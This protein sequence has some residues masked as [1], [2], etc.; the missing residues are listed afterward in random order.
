MADNHAR[1]FVN[2]APRY[3][4]QPTDNRYIRYALNKEQ[5]RTR[6]TRLVDLSVSGLSFLS[7]VEDAPR[8]GE[9]VKLEIPLN[10]T[11]TVAW[12]ARVVRVEEYSPYKWYMKNLDHSSESEVIVALNFD[13]L[14][15]GHKNEIRE[16]LNRKFDE[17][18][19]KRRILQ[20]QTLTALIFHRVWP[21]VLY[22]LCIGATIYGL[23]Y[24]SR[25]SGNYDPDRGAPWGQRYPQFNIFDS[26]KNSDDK[27]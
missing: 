20:L 1:K 9:K 14:P 18:H 15:E 8:V 7:L 4:L 25:P 16:T 6:T 22:S 11:K 26:D 12:W 3:L 5:D 17:L 19:K 23:Y 2:R 21:I 24:F 13:D 10:E 27:N